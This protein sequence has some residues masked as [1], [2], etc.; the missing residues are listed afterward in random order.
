MR[1]NAALSSTTASENARSGAVS[2]GGWLHFPLDILCGIKNDVHMK[3]SQKEIEK[4]EAILT[5]REEGYGNRSIMIEHDLSEIPTVSA[6]FACLKRIGIKV[7]P[8]NSHRLVLKEKIDF[9]LW[10]REKRARELEERQLE[11]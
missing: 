5:M 8:P 10:L 4:I 2:F 9:Q 11:D 7:P 3:L 6:F 1:H